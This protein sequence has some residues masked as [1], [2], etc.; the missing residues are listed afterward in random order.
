MVR[1]IK[2]DHFVYF[3][4]G[5]T[6][7]IAD[8]RKFKDEGGVTC[9]RFLLWPSQK[10]FDLYNLNEDDFFDGGTGLIK[11]EYPDF[12]VEVLEN[13]PGCTRIWVFTSFNGDDT[14]VSTREAH[15]TETIN[16]LERE[17]MSLKA[18]VAALH[19]QIHLERTN[20]LA[21]MNKMTEIVIAARKAA[22]KT[23]GGEQED[24]EDSMGGMDGG[25][26]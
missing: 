19:E 9:W 4:D 24:I 14:H 12:H 10:Q 3:A 23:Q 7:Q 5:T 25:G 26:G 22:G 8:K 16:Y 15:L 1:F 17:M 21:S 13:N 6:S 20:Q 2:G 11:R 18:N